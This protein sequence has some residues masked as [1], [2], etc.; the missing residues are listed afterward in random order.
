[1]TDNLKEI[2]LNGAETA[3][4]NG[5]FESSSEYRPRLL[6]N[7][8]GHKV[9]NSIKDEL[10]DCEEFFISVAFITKGGLTPL[11]QDLK[12][13]EK[14]GIKGKI[15]TTDY[16]YFTEPEALRKLND[17]SNI[18]IKMYETDETDGFH[19]KGYIFKNNGIYKAI[20]GS[21]NLT[22]NALTI[23]KEWNIGFSS[24]YDGEILKSLIDEFNDLWERSSLIDDIIVEYENIY[25]NK[26]NFRDFNRDYKEVK[27]ETEAELVP[28][29]MQR[30][31]LDNLRTLVLNGEDR[32]LL[33][34]ATGTGK[35]YA[36]AFAVKDFQPKKFLFIVHR[37]QILNQAIKSFK[38]VF[39]GEDDKFG[40]L[41]GNSKEFDKDY[42]FS[43]VQTMSKEE[44]Y[45]KFDEDEFDFIVIDEVHK[46]GALSYKKLL[47]YF[48]PKFWLGMTASP[49]RTD[50]EN[51]YEIFDYNV[52]LDI[53]LQDALEEDL[54]CPFHY[55]GISDLTVDGEVLDDESDFRYLVSNDRVN[56]LLEKS[57]YYGHTGERC[58]ALVFCS[59]KREARELADAFTQRGHPSVFLSGDNSQDEREEAIYRLT[60]DDAGDP[61]EYIFT[62]DIFNEGVDIPEV[63]Q[64]LLVRPTQSSIIF[65]Q[66]LG[67]GLRK[68]KN[69]EYVVIID[70]IGNYKNNFLIPIAL[71]GDRTYDKDNIRRYLMEGSKVIPGQ[72]SISFDEISKKRIYKAI[73]N[74]SFSK[75]ALFKEKYQNLKFRLGGI[76]YLV[77]FYE[78]G[79]F[80][81]ELILSHNQYDSYYNFLKKIDN[82]YDEDIDENDNLSLKFISSKIIKGIRPHE[83]VILRYLRYNKYFT[84]QAIEDFLY[85]EY[86]LENQ[87]ESIKGAINLL[88]LNFYK[89]ESTQNRDSQTTLIETT[90]RVS[91][92]DY[93][94]NTVSSAIGKVDGFDYEN[95]FFNFDIS[96]DN[97]ENNKYHKFVISD[98]FRKALTNN[99]YLKHF[100][101]AIEYTLLKY[102]SVYRVED[103]VFKYYA[104]YSREDVLKLLNWEFF[105]NGQNIG[106]YKIKYNTCPIFV[107]YDKKEDISETINYEDEFDSR[108]VFSWMSRNNR[109]VE[110]NELKPLVNYTD[111][112]VRLFIK[113]SDDEGLDFYYIG[114]LSPL[115]HKQLFREIDGK[116]NPIVNFKF[117]IDHTVDENLYN[118]FMD[119]LDEE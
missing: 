83:A 65:I 38:R 73:D 1:M 117:K 46:A 81:P 29:S 21:S 115:S 22:L 104:K 68:F 102:D 59:T 30:D 99:A 16:L 94:A 39:N 110:S 75:I 72:S 85:D 43:T 92:E 40:L 25:N 18:E 10:K 17:L 8:N 90:S 70:F 87:F 76:P 50:G 107:T 69:K 66:Q 88:S 6:V 100:E 63:N 13:L 80:N 2:I 34:S 53:R 36:A 71:S 105:M 4:I 12:E 74:T 5:E 89:K 114:K 58:K 23:N 106:G 61:I 14:R 60:S 51:I 48:K 49:D 37:E 97:L 98:Y 45:T 31:F 96:L 35:T 19:T 24:L 116:Q 93:Q 3:F 32:A 15:I 28:N 113:K 95:I 67:R 82:S 112:D 84:I 86:G 103:D 27:E 41:S 9:L 111:L 47:N 55:F 62:V 57:E 91:F 56:Y 11:L 33:V 44:Y 52:P 119:K 26:K 108:D 54:L 7:S 77:D 118:Y 109:R 78:N 20:V 101:D 64:V 79:E 42:L